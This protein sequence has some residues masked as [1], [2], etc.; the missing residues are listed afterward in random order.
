[1]DTPVLS[2]EPTAL[3]LVCVMNNQRDLDIARILGWYRIPLRSA[4]KVV[5][6]DY[7]AFYQTAGFDSETRWRINFAAKVRGHELLTRGEIL[8]DE[9][10]HPHAHEEYYKVEIG[11]L[12]PLANPI[13]AGSWKRLTFLYTTGLHLMTASSIK[14]LAVG[15]EE[16]VVLWK[17]L[18]ERA[19]AGGGYKTDE[20]S[21][22]EFE[23]DPSLMLALLG[24]NQ[25]IESKSHE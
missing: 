3:V 22:S 16:R 8:K 2:I 23:M 10:E 25:A 12:I 24:M 20:T 6:V 1:M 13:R 15:A 11:P 5:A 9:P 21:E 14:Q 19:L 4:P 7:L 18:R 17:T